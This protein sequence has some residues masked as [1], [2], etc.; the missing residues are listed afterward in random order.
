MGLT[1]GWTQVPLEDVCEIHNGSTPSKRNPSYWNGDIL[2]ATPTDIT[3]LTS[4]YIS[5]TKDKITQAGFK[6]CSTSLLPRGSLLFTSRASIGKMA[7]NK[8]PICTNQGFKSMVCGDKIIPEF[9]YYQLKLMKSYLETL[10]S[11]STFLEIS[12]A[13]M[14][15]VKILLPPLPTQKKIVAI[16]EKA[17]ELKRL[18]E[19]ADKWMGEFLQSVFIE[20][21]GD[22]VKNEKGWDVTSLKYMLK[23]KTQ[24]GLYVP[25]EYYSTTNG[26]EMVHMSD[27]FYGIVERDKLKRVSIEQ[28]D[29]DKYN[30]T[31][32]DLLVAR[33]SLNYE[34]SAKPCRIPKSI[35]PLVFESSLIRINIDKEKILPIYLFFYLSNERAR[36]KYV[37]KYVTK[38]TISGIN[39]AGLNKVKI[40][41]PELSLQK[42]F[43]TIVEKVEQ[44]KGEQEKSKGQI[45]NMFNALMQKAFKGELV[46]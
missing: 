21:F 33:R 39:Q 14:K 37:F 34:G 26:V 23:E 11:G 36:A 17:E 16:L 45:D 4:K 28:K 22:P 19:E 42:K 41:V 5:E 40:L 1:D 2:W 43:A 46:A 25:K 9:L 38:S 12:M 27:A 3:K 6:S 31:S 44:M 29:I 32:D 24:N 7:I 20:M 35:E 30:L 18:R 8:T 15:K 10:G 13:K